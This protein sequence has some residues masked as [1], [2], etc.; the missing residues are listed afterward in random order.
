V[1]HVIQRRSRQSRPV[2]FQLFP[3]VRC[4]IGL[5]HYP[6][7]EHVVT[8]LINRYRTNTDRHITIGVGDGGHGGTCPL[9]NSGKYFSGKNH[10]KFGHFVNFSCIYFPAKMSCAPRLTE[11]L[12]LCILLLAVCSNRA[13]CNGLAAI[14]NANFDSGF[15]TPQN[16]HSRRG[17]GPMSNTILSVSLPNGISFRLTTSAG[18][19]SVTDGQTDHATGTSE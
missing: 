4:I 8:A 3:V 2:A 10:V 13:I 19:T 17:P 14:C 6:L 15:R 18:C 9:P 5:H 1:C 12:R 16:S 11:L 7:N